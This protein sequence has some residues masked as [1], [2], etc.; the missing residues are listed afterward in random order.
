MVGILSQ[1]PTNSPRQA[2]KYLTVLSIRSVKVKKIQRIQLDFP[3]TTSLLWWLVF[4]VCFSSFSSKLHLLKG[5]VAEWFSSFFL[6]WSS[7]FPSPLPKTDRKNRKENCAC[8]TRY[9]TNLFLC[10]NSKIYL[11]VVPLIQRMCEHEDHHHA[12]STPG[13]VHI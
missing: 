3:G 2:L 7:I 6:Y 8:S 11:L 9:Q 13:G 12:S 5:L 4:V 10:G 1:S